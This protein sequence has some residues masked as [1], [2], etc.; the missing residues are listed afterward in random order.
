MRSD[1]AW[2][3]RSCYLRCHRGESAFTSPTEVARRPSRNGVGVRLY[4]SAL[5]A[6]E[7]MEGRV[8]ASVAAKVR[9]KLKPAA[10][11]EGQTDLL[12]ELARIEEPDGNA[13]SSSTA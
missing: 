6:A 12:T 5:E 10:P 2:C 13:R 3:S 11:I 7:L 9:A 1:A 4:I 8:P